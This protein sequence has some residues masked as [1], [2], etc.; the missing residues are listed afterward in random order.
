MQY[1]RQVIR[2]GGSLC[3]TI[4]ADVSR[5]L[6]LKPNDQIALIVDDDKIIITKEGD[7]NGV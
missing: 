3:I 2:N 7:S 5:F 6:K 4:P 1:K